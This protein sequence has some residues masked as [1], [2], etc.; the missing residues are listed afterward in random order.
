MFINYFS[1][2]RGVIDM[3]LK[4]IVIK[5]F[6]GYKDNT[7]VEF[8]NLTTFIGKNDVG[9]ST[10]LEALDIF[11]NDGKGSSK[12]DKE[13]VNK[14]CRKD[15]NLET[16]IAVS[17]VNLPNEVDIDSGNKTT[18]Q[19]EYLLNNNNEFEIIKKYKDGGK[20]A[21]VYIKAKH[22]TNS[23]CCDLL[24][25]KNGDLKK[26]V[27]NLNLNNCDKTKNASMRVAIWNYYKDNLD[28]KEIELDVEQKEGDIKN[29][30][31]NIQKYLPIYSLFK[32]DRS[33]SDEDVEIQDPLTI[34]VKRILKS[35]ELSEKLNF[36][37]EQVI[38]ELKQVSART[39]TK[40][41]EMN[42]E[43]AKTL[44]P[45]FPEQLKWESVFKDI[46]ITGDNNIQINKRGSGVKRLILLNFFV[47]EAENKKN[48]N[49]SQ[50]I[51]YAIEE[52]ETSQ[53]IEHQNNMIE[54]LKTLSRTENTQIILTTHSSNIVKQLDFNVLRMIIKVND[55][56][57]I[58]NV[59]KKLLNYPSLNEVNY[60]AFNEP[61]IEFHN[62]LYGYLQSKAMD[63]NNN[64]YR[65]DSFDN[66][67]SKDICNKN[68]TW[69]KI[70]EDGT[71]KPEPVTLQTYI[72]NFVHHP[73]NRQNKKYTPEKFKQSIEEMIK[74]IRKLNNVN[75]TKS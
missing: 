72:R 68:E 57:E 48:T 44:Q 39:L 67:L 63:E 27:D 15:D 32:S 54:A 38:N 12:I 16:I 26:I 53:H 56:T 49:T 10:I 42:P 21:K 65:Q 45:K 37:S 23:K 46:S 3:K 52:P 75:S 71:T 33:N 36:I 20:A 5:N 58:K 31:V 24:K 30:W 7:K 4:S 60:F 73:E 8:G 19:A 62:E 2:E 35:Q 66:W 22:P 29:I 64:N 1:F 25:K 50:N 28:L 6:R 9:K 14:Q 74:I 43:I 70:K 13:D 69:I 11:F 18:L 17:F 40:I 55:T 41:K 59:E 61:S 51:I 34:A 47:A